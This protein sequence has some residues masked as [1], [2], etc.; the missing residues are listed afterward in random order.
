MC[1]SVR[2]H[3]T[4]AHWS[5]LDRH[6]RLQNGGSRLSFFLNQHQKRTRNQTFSPC[7]VART[8]SWRSL[9]IRCP[10]SADT[11]VVRAVLTSGLLLVR[12]DIQSSVFVVHS[13]RRSSS[14]FAR[15]RSVQQSK[16]ELHSRSKVPNPNTPPRFIA[17][18][19]GLVSIVQCDTSQYILVTALSR[20][21]I[22]ACSNFAGN[23]TLLVHHIRN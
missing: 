10:V 14:S 11:N 4:G 6:V 16:P 18:G 19:P 1:Y 17:L 23:P 22:V 15:W 21:A 7:Q 5:V 3:G 20:S 9:G 2:I 13:G 8:V 12:S